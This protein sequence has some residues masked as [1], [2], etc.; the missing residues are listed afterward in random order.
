[1]SKFIDNLKDLTKATPKPMG[2]ITSRSAAKKPKMQ[3]IANLT[4][5]DS[6][7]FADIVAPADAVIVK[8]GSLSFTKTALKKITRLADKKSWGMWIENS[9]RDTTLL[10]IENGCDF[11]VITASDSLHSVPQPDKGGSIL[12]INDSIK[13]GLLRTIN[14]LSIDAVLIDFEQEHTSPLNWSQLMTVQHFAA[15]ITKPLLLTV[16]PA[17]TGDELQML[18]ETGIDGVVIDTAESNTDL[19]ALRQLIDATTF[20]LPRKRREIVALLPHVE[21]APEPITEPFE[22]EEPDED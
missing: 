1:M 12:K 15:L 4:E 13:E 21:S 10:A 8:A 2:F 19:T 14:V 16:P 20:P 7:G 9:P 11:L 17:I 3:L 5:F 22:P 6:N 18:W